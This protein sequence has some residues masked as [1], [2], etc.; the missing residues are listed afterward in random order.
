MSVLGEICHK[1]DAETCLGI[2]AVHQ[3]AAVL[4]RE[5]LDW[6][7]WHFEDGVQLV[8]SFGC[9]LVT[10][11]YHSEEKN[12]LSISFNVLWE[13]RTCRKTQFTSQ[14]RSLPRCSVWLRA[15]QAQLRAAR[16]LHHS[17]VQVNRSTCGNCWAGLR[18]R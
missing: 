13:L 7:L 15:E 10:A 16:Q 8:P 9:M 18:L 14:P 6:K 1:G 3:R 11:R 5:A 2:T 17:P 4:R 12:P